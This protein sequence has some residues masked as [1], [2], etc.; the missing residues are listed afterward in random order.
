M[1]KNSNASV[2]NCYSTGEINGLDAGGIF[3]SFCS[4]SISLSYSTGSIN[5]V[6]AGGICGPTSNEILLS[7]SYSL[8]KISDEATNA[9]GLFGVFSG[10]VLTATN[11]YVLANTLGNSNN[12]YP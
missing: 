9:G 12:V 6:N 4:G 8:G 1:G 2:S 5:G 11:C 3:G 10:R 7:N